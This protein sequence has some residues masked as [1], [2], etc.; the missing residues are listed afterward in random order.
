VPP[1]QEQT[2]PELKQT[3]PELKEQTAQKTWT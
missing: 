2:P 1:D 3:P